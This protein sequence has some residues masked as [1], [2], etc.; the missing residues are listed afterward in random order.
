MDVE[1]LRRYRSTV[2]R[3]NYWAVDQSTIALSSGEAELYGACMAAHQAVGMES[4]ARE[5]G[6]NFDAME[7]QVDANAA[8]GIIG[9]Q[10]PGKVR[11]LDLS[12][13]SARNQ[14]EQYRFFELFSRFEFDFRRCDISFEPFDFVACSKFN[15]M[16]RD[17]TCACAVACLHPHNSISNVVVSVT[18][19]ADM[20]KQ[21]YIEKRCSKKMKPLWEV[22]GFF[23]RTSRKVSDVQ[24][25]RYTWVLVAKDKS[26]HPVA[27]S[28]A[29]SRSKG[30]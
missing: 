7:L 8:V 24:I 3:L 2:A 30:F 26:N 28:S 4:M 14:F 21:K 29:V 27:V 5:Q 1:K 6:V 13:C 9:R 10:R 16:Q 17:C 15:H 11:H 20:V 12:Y 19:H 25:F 22:K 18:N 23:N